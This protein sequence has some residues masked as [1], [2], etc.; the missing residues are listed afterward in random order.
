MNNA[1]QRDKKGGDGTRPLHFRCAF[2]LYRTL[3]TVLASSVPLHQQTCYAYLFQCHGKQLLL[4]VKPGWCFELDCGF[5]SLNS[6][7]L[8]SAHGTPPSSSLSLSSP[9]FTEAFDTQCF[10]RASYARKKRCEGNLA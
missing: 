10:A 2:C 8:S 3:F 5:S 1:Q 6:I 7:S 4:D 9:G